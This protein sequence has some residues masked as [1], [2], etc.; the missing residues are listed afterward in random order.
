MSQFKIYGHERFL[1]GRVED[2]STAIHRVAVDV[3]GL[4][5]SKRFHRFI[6]MPEGYF[7]APEDRSECYLIIECM[8]FEGRP[9]ETKKAFYEGLI[10]GLEGSVGVTSNDIEMTF[11][12]TPRHDW[13]IRGRPGDELE[14]TYR[15]EV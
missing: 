13:L 3:L 1:K 15:V 2:I 14:L 11:I 8:L 10:A 12:E 4:P 7:F 5:E 6:P 9:V